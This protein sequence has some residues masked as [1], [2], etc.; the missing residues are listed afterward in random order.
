MTQEHAGD[1]HAIVMSSLIGPDITPAATAGGDVVDPSSHWEQVY[2][3]K[4]PEEVSW[5]QSTAAVALAIITERRPERDSAIIDVGSGA[6]TLIDNLLDSGYTRLTALDLSPAALAKSQ[7]RLGERAAAVEWLVGDVLTADLP[8]ASFDL[9]HDRAV[10]H[11]LTSADARHRYVAHVGRVLRPGGLAVI[12]T[13]AED[14]P[15]RCS[16]LDTMRYSA[17]ELHAEFGADFRLLESRREAH[18]TPWGSVQAFTVC[19]CV[20]EPQR[21]A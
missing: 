10:F 21:W 3:S 12:A 13:F 20:F 15:V 9:W 6:S 7:Q 5:F 4:S 14:G 2:R 11:F 19:V 17:S 16:G 18:V 1:L 8:P